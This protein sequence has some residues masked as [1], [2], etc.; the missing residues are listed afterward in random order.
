MSLV[1]W[2]VTSSYSLM[3]DI[4]YRKFVADTQGAGDINRTIL[5]RII[6]ANAQTEYGRLY[7]FAGINT[8]SAYKAGVPL[9]SYS[10]YEPY[11]GR[12]V[13][14]ETNL[15]SADPVTYFGLSSGTTG[16]QKY[17]PITQRTARMM[18]MNMMFLQQGLLGRILPQTKHCGRGLLLMNMVQGDNTQQGIPTGSGTSGGALAMKKIFPYFWTSPVS[19]LKIAD[20]RVANYLHLLFALKERRLSYLGAPFPSSIVQMFSVLEEKWPELVSDIARGKITQ[21]IE[22]VS[23]VRKELEGKLRPDSKRAAEL[24]Q[25]LSKG[26][27]GIASR[28]WPKMVYV[29]CVTGGSFNIYLEKLRYYTA[30]LPVYSAVYGATE[31]LVGIGARIDTVSY[32][33]T[34]RP[35]YYEF[36]PLDEADAPNPTTYDLDQVEVGKTYEVVITNFAGFYRYRL[37]DVVKVVGRYNQTPVIEFMYRKGQLLNL[38]GEKTPE[39]AVQHAVQAAL[40]AQGTRVLDYTV[41]LNLDAAIGCYR[42]YIEASSAEQT[43]NMEATRLKLEQ[44]LAEANPRY[45]AGL[46]S[47]RISPLELRLVQSGTFEKIRNELIKRGASFNQVKVPRLMKD[48]ELIALL[49]RS[50][51]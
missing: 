26:L 44:C 22:L 17:I 11:I 16:K 42:F 27:Q 31:A 45:L 49:D 51:L 29:S 4:F 7:N 21:D 46:N 43:P 18:N 47:N 28:I 30:G 37:G 34:P 6:A 23:S 40:Q 14:G 2:A 3:A 38:A 9:S 5:Q 25:E 10:D 24:E 35:A 39:P 1:R 8:A 48:Q 15:L 41:T 36:I 50:I 19:V 32:V 13:N 12:M 33:V 20:Q